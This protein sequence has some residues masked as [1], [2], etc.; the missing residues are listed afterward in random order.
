VHILAA[1]AQ[2]EQK[3]ISERTKA[4][5]A[6]ARSRGVRLGNP[7]LRLGTA[8]SAATARKARTVRTEERALELREVINDAE[9]QGH[10]TLLS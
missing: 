9:R 5:L 10:R 1:V 4:A 3:A 7:R 8:A 6:A 2:A